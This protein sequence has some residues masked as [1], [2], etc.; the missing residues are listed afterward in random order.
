MLQSAEEIPEVPEV[1]ASVYWFLSDT[2]SSVLL[3]LSLSRAH[4]RGTP[5]QSGILVPY[6]V[7]FG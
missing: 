5:S 2:G 1:S 4:A 6:I 7:I 3:S